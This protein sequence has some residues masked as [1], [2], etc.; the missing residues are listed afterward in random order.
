MRP[1]SVRVLV[2][3]LCGQIVGSCA[4]IS[5]VN[6]LVC[7]QDTFPFDP[8]F[9]RV[10]NPIINGGYVLGGGAICMELLTKQVRATMA[11]P[12]GSGGWALVINVFI[13]NET[14]FVRANHKSR[15]CEEMNRFSSG[16]QTSP[17]DTAR[18]CLVFP[19][20]REL[21]EQISAKKPPQEIESI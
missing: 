11:P 12:S 20:V 21:S 14:V 13:P 18:V 6:L 2:R 8:P 9:V 19:S 3:R 15:K 16:E 10:I 4:A 7:P 1:G 17:M 5:D